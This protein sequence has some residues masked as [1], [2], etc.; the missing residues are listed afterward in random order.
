VPTCTFVGCEASPEQS[1][2]VAAVDWRSAS[3]S[4]RKSNSVSI[5]A[6]SV[7]IGL[8]RVCWASEEDDSKKRLG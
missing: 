4:A 6:A 1:L 3:S 7:L 8:P 2:G 5:S